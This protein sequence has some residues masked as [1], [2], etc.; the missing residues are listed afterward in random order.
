M[1]CHFTTVIGATGGFLK[2]MGGS[3]YLER[4]LPEQIGSS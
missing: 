3:I 1:V 4:I 2:L